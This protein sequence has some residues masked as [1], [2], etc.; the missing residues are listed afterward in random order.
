MFFQGVIASRIIIAFEYV[1]TQHFARKNFK[2]YGESY[3]IVRREE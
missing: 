3:N 2:K 1:K